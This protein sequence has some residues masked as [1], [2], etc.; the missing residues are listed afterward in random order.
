MKINGN[1]LKTGMIINHKNGM[2]KV[3]NT[4]AVKPGKGG[5]FNQVELRNVENNTKLNERFRSNETLERLYVESKD[6][7]FTY[8]S[9]DNVYFMDL[10]TFEEFTISSKLL[11]DRKPFLQDNMQ[12][13]IELVNNKAVTVKLPEHI[14][15]EVVET[16][17]VI[18]GQ[19]VAS[20]FKPALLSNK[21]K[22]MVPGHIEIGMKIVVSS[23]TLTYLERFKS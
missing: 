15:E 8:E 9:G 18:K 16:E 5:A 11:E 3:V 2:W 4:Q 6:Y 13:T 20:S 7:Q 12:V 22:I 10:I 21:V 23:S 1:S 14:V 17:A 19:T